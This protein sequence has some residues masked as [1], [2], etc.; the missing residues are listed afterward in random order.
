MIRQ[1]SIPE[2]VELTLTNRCNLRCRYCHFFDSPNEVDLELSTGEWLQF[3][4]ELGRAQVLRATVSGGE[5]L[6]RQDFRELIDGLVR[7]RMRFSL[8]SNGGL[9]TP[10]IAD[11]LVKTRRCEMVQISLDG[12]CAAVHDSF[13]GQGSFDAAIAALR[14]LKSRGI[15]RAVRITIGKHNLGFLQSTVRFVLDELQVPL[16]SINWA[17]TMTESR[18]ESESFE[19]N[20]RQHLSALMELKALGSAYLA[21]LS[22]ESPPLHELQH[23]PAL[24]ERQRQGRPNSV[25]HPLCPAPFRRFTVRADGAFCLCPHLPE[26]VWGW[27][28]RTKLTEAWLAGEP[29]NTMRRCTRD[30]IQQ[31]FPRCRECEFG[32]YCTTSCPALRASNEDGV[33]SCWCI[34]RY[35]EAVPDFDFERMEFRS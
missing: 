13:R 6:M 4:D 11:F 19:L 14:L 12:H 17:S 15:P 5:A 31:D 34:K 3:F 1:L 21:R 20:F 10:E 8:L 27:A 7:N 2:R 28:N 26:T 18:K 24:L 16:V 25:S 32:A 9:L 23:F 33:G 30:H 29:L 35:R 22:N